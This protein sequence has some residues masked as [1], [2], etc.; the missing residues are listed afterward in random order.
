MYPKMCYE[1][2]CWL[3]SNTKQNFALALSN[4]ETRRAWFRFSRLLGPQD[5]VGMPQKS[6]DLLI[7]QLFLALASSLLV[8]IK[9][10]E[11]TNIFS[12]PI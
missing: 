4:S 5:A 3:A 1:C 10:N 6:G 8:Q 7:C 2:H 11:E 12:T 9:W